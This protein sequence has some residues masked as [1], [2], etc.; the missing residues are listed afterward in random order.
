MALEDSKQAIGAVSELLKSL[1]T[2]D[3]DANTVDI[4][5]PEEVSATNCP[6]LNIFL[7]QIDFDGQ[8]RNH[9][10]D[11]GQRAPLWFVLRYLLT[12]FDDNK[13][14]DTSSAHNLLGEGMLVLNEMNFIEPAVLG[15]V[16]N[17][18]PLKIT[19]DRADSE[20]LSKI[21]QGSDEKYRLSAAFQVRPVMIAPSV[22][23]RYTL[24]VKSVGSQAEEGVALMPSLGPKLESLKP[25][26]FAQGETITLMGIDI[27]TVIE[28]VRFGNIVFPVTAAKIG[29]IKVVINSTPGLSAGSYPI[30]ALRRL[31]GDQVISSNALLG[32]LLPTVTNAIPSALTV[33]DGLF[34]GKLTLTGELLGGPDDSIFIAFYQNGQTLLMLEGTGAIDQTTLMVNVDSENALPAGNYYIILRVNG[35]QAS[36]AP[37]VDWSS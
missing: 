23:P 34:S 35:A 5:R 24:P 13:E 32:T 22:P 20:L 26:K 9:P 8:L 7:Y 36:N 16:D 28:E 31:K 37:M 19:F 6:K 3:T 11:E 12:A 1:L 33:T 4:G 25:E 10:L 30:T 27:G 29:K 18:E 17:P 15:L 21:M 14:S 2:L